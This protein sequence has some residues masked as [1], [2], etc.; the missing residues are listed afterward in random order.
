MVGITQVAEVDTELTYSQSCTLMAWQKF[1]H[2][3]MPSCLSEI[4]AF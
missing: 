1:R 4:E 2:G 3:T